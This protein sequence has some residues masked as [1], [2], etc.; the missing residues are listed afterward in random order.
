[1][2]AIDEESLSQLGRWPWS[3]RLHA[4]LIDK[5]KNDGARVIGMD[6][7]FSE[8]EA[9]DQ[10]ADALLAESIR[11]A[12]NVVLPVLIESSRNNGQMLEKLPLPELSQNALGLGRVH[13]ELDE[14]GI[15]RSVFLWEG[16]GTPTWPTFAQAVLSAA[17]IDVPG[18]A[19]TPPSVYEVQ[20]FVLVRRDQ[21]KVDF[22]GPPG[23]VPSLSYVQVLTGNF[24]PDCSKTK[25]SWSVQQLRAWGIC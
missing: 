12:G 18:L 10:P 15:A 20:P 11:Q 14:D 4:A 3:R 2:V 19:I 13:V 17:E 9:I 25:L 24:L 22:L 7:I 23:Q 1:M 5:L 8:P 16:L 6:L 21:R